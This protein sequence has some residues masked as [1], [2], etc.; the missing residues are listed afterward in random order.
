MSRMSK[1]VLMRQVPDDL[2]AAVDDFARESAG[3]SG[4]PSRDRALRLLI[5]RGLAAPRGDGAIV[6][7]DGAPGVKRGE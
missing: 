6:R 5:Q 4:R 1:N 7:G 3:E 2:L